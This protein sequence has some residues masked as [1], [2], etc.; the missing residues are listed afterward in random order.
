M[1]DQTKDQNPKILEMAKKKRYIYL[2]EKLRGGKPATTLSKSELKELEKFAADPDSPGIVDSM[3][4]V[5][6]AFEV[7]DRT[8]RYWAKDGM[9][10]TPDGKYD[11]TEIQAWHFLKKHPEKSGKETHSQKW[12]GEYREYKA[13]LMRIEYERKLGNLIPKEEVEKQ[14]VQRIIAVK[15]AFLSLPRA[16]APQLVGMEPREIESV[17]MGRIKEIIENF[18]QGKKVTHKR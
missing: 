5:A 3:V 11:L 14:M 16:L 6:K 13:R 15:R 2:L 12:E 10:M 1:E 4:K 17:L 18:A 9:P 7:S 8:V